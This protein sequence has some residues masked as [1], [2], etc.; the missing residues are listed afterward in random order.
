MQ[1]STVWFNALDGACLPWNMIINSIDDLD[2]LIWSATNSKYMNSER[3]QF[4]LML[5]IRKPW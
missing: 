1:I 3:V 2:L 4:T 5:T